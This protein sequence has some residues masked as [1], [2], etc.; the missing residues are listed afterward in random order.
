M[1]I[2]TTNYRDD[3]VW[4]N[5]DLPCGI[6]ATLC[7]YGASVYSLSLENAPLILTLEDKEEF[8]NC[9][10]YFG[11]TLGRVAGRIDCNV[12]LGG[13]NFKLTPTKD[14]TYSLHGGDANS[15]SYKVWNFKTKETMRKNIVSFSIVD[16]DGENGFPGKATIK[17]IYT[18]Y[19]NKPILRID[20]KGKT[21]KETYMNLSNHMYFS[22]NGDLDISDYKLKMPCSHYGDVDETVFIK[23][24]KQVPNELDFRRGTKLG[25][26]LQYLEN[27]SF[28]KTIDNTFLFDKVRTT[29]P[30]VILKSK[31]FSLKLYTDYPAFNIYVDNSQTPVKFIN[32]P[33]FDMRRGIALEPQ[34]YNLNLDSLKLNKGDKYKHIIKYKFKK[35]K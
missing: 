23:E 34:L 9:P 18:F 5:L 12:N 16:P 3:I 11:K 2:T 27:N 32:N 22:F 25:P 31:D 29:K 15:L 30:Q 28:L 35:I 13:E 1:A 7:N 24:T 4:I 19:K 6:K 21:N 20:F 26:R 33:D 14:F 10:Q 17:V 8:L